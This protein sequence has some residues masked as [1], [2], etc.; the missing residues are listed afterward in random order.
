MTQFEARHWWGE[1]YA[2]EPSAVYRTMRRRFP[3]HG[4]LAL[5]NI[6][7]VRAFVGEPAADLVSAVAL[8]PTA[9]GPDAQRA[10]PAVAELL[11]AA[12]SAAIPIVHCRPGAEWASYT[13]DTVKGERGEGYANARPGA[14]DFV[15]EAAPMDGELIIPKPKASAF[16]DTHL[17][18]TLRQLGVERLLVTGGSTS[19]CV[20]ASVVDGFSHGFRPYV[21]EEAVFDRSRVSAAASLWDLDARYAD[22]IQLQEALQMVNEAPVV[23]SSRSEVGAR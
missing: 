23:A 9:C 7:I 11:A 4:N 17:A 20:R 1:L 10:L 15:D 5:L 21:V 2:D 6:D 22:V 18:T 8:W 12:R 3:G 13:G 14:V 16:F 19:G